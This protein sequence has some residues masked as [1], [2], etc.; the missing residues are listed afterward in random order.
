M[1][2][3]VVDAGVFGHRG[4]SGLDV[5]DDEFAGEVLV[6]EGFQFLRR[7]VVFLERRDAGSE[8]A[9][10]TESSRVD[11][12][13]MRDCEQAIER[14]CYSAQSEFGG[15]SLKSRLSIW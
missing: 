4:E 3:D 15:C 8:Q 6:P 7:H 13:A 11:C 9:S 14:R 12:L 2:G 5:F 10:G 1:D